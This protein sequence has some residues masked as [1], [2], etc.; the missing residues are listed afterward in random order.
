MWE[1]KS[2]NFTYDNTRPHIVMENQYIEYKVQLSPR[3]S[4]RV[5]G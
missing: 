3:Q 1:I 4:E 5:V 2:P